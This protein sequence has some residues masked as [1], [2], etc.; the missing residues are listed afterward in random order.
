MCVCVPCPPFLS[1]LVPLLFRF[2]DFQDGY[3][4]RCNQGF[5]DLRPERP[6]RLCQQMVNEC[7]RTE[8]NSCDKNAKC[9]DEEVDLMELIG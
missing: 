1:L 3:Q 5:K 4:C 9:I 7:A 2:P 6:G 8:T